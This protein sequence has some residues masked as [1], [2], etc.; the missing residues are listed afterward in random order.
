M[1]LYH[2]C[3]NRILFS[4]N[5]VCTEIELPTSENLSELPVSRPFLIEPLL[6]PDQQ[7]IAFS[8]DQ[9][10]YIFDRTKHELFSLS[11]K[12]NGFYIADFSSANRLYYSD[13]K[14]NIW[15]WDPNHAAPQKLFHLARA[16]HGFQAIA[17]SPNERYLAF[18][19]YKGEN[20][21]LYLYDFSDNTTRDLHTSAYYF[22]W[23]DDTHIIWSLLGGL[24]ILDITTGKSTTLLRDHRAIIKKCRTPDS[25]VLEAFF[26]QAKSYV[27]EDINLLSMQDDR[28]LFFLRLSATGCDSYRAIW[29]IQT[30]GTDP[31]FHFTIPEEFPQSVIDSV[32]PNGQLFWEVANG[33]FLSCDGTLHAKLSANWRPIRYTTEAKR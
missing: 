28:I 23:L 4:E 14:N 25:S 18:L 5:G 19:R 7:Y 3:E 24:K 9:Q 26:K 29:S 11:E 10:L 32:H 16:I 17:I 1:F 15:V 27:F 31:R 20:K 21:R 30:D 13:M 8:T 2:Y 22:H 33:E 12:V 6:S